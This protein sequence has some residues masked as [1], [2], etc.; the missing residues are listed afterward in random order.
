MFILL[1]DKEPRLKRH[2]LT[3]R[4]TFIVT[5]VVS[6][7]LMK[8]ISTVLTKPHQRRTKDF[9]FSPY[10]SQRSLSFSTVTEFNSLLLTFFLSF[11]LAACLVVIGRM[12]FKSPQYLEV[13]LLAPVM[14]FMT[15]SLGA[16]GQMIFFKTCR[17]SFPIHHRPL[18]SSTLSQFWGRHWNLWV[19]DW[20]KD[21]SQPFRGQKI[22]RLAVI[23]LVSGFFHEIWI[24]LPYWLAYRKSYFGTM[25]AYFICQA[26]AS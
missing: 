5:F 16:L 22:K 18:S 3:Y 20:L 13:L 12:I 9:F 26:L 1:S 2:Y 24:N 6:Y 23:F 17:N 10:I 21:I 25:M 4:I 11:S 19:Q 15:E 14:L 7:L 8:I